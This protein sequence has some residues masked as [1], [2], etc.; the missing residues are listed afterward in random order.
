MNRMTQERKEE[1]TRS[2]K[3]S[4]V[5]FTALSVAIAPLFAKM[6][7]PLYS[8]I[9]ESEEAFDSFFTAK[10]RHDVT[11]TMKHFSTKDATYTESVREESRSCDAGNTEDVQRHRMLESPHN[12][13]GSFA[14]VANVADGP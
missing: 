4:L 3:I 6:P 10:S 11:A 2:R 1:M 9:A 12:R 13:H 5:L 8:Q 14:G 7:E